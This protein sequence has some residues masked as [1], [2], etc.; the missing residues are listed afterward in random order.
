MHYFILI[1]IIHKYTEKPGDLVISLIIFASK[2]ICAI[3]H[4]ILRLCFTSCR[5]N[6]YAN[7][8]EKI[9]AWLAI[10]NKEEDLYFR[11]ISMVEQ[12]RSIDVTYNTVTL[13]VHMN[14]YSFDLE[15]FQSISL[16][17]GLSF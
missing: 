3:I 2:A 5:D 12:N 11:S 7:C 17:K 13:C 8:T 4:K 16:Y 14:K 10:L 6:P 9:L 15:C 1:F